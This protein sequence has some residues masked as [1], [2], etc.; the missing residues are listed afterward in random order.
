MTHKQW[1]QVTRIF[2]D[3]IEV[4][5]EKR[6][7]WLDD[8]C[9]DDNE[10]YK[11]VQSLLK[12]YTSPGLPDLSLKEVRQS[13]VSWMELQDKKG[14]QIGPYQ[15]QEM[16]G[17]GGM[18]VVYRAYDCRLDR[19]VAIK[20]PP[21]YWSLNEQTKKRFLNEARIAASLDHPNI[22]T[23]Y[24]ADELDDGT[25][26]MAMAF[27]Q[28]ETLQQRLEQGPLDLDDAVDLII[29]TASGLEAAHKK[30]LIHRDIKPANLILTQNGTLKVLDFGIA[31]A[32]DEGIT[33]S[34][35][36]PGTEAY[37]S[38]EQVHGGRVDKR[39]D[40]WSM[41]VIFYEMLTGELPRNEWVSVSSL[42][43]GVPARIDELLCQLL[44]PDPDNR[45]QSAGELVATLETMDGQFE[46]VDSIS[47]GKMKHLPKIGLFS[48][49]IL[50]L[51]LSVI[52]AYQV[53]NG[54]SLFS[55]ATGES[56]VSHTLAVLPFNNISGDPGDEYFSDGISEDLL[57]YLARNSGFSV[58]SRSTV[59]HY[60]DSGRA[61]PDIGRELGAT[62]IINGSVQRADNRVRINVQL[63]DAGS[64]HQ[65]WGDRYDREL[66]DIFEIQTDIVRSIA[67]RLEGHILSSSDITEPGILNAEAH[68][69]YLQGRFHWHR[70]S[71]DGLRK[72]AEF[73]EKAVEIEPEYSTAWEGLADAYAVLGFYDY[74][75][76]DQ[77]FPKARE[78]ARRALELK[79]NSASAWA[80]L[81]Y[82]ALYYDWNL[83]WGEAAFRRSINLDPRN[84]KAR[85]WYANMLTAAGRFDEAEREMLRAQE[86]DP[87]SLIANAA[88]GW[89]YYQA[90]KNEDAIRQLNFTLELNPDFELAY[91]WKGWTLEAMERYDE[92]LEMLE[93]A[94]SRST[95]SNIV[96]ASLARLHGLRGET[97]KAESLLRELEKSEMYIP[98]YEIGKAYLGL[99]RIEQAGLWLERAIDDRSH[100]MVFLKVDPQIS[101]YLDTN[102]IAD[103]AVRVRSESSRDE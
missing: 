52:S 39:T 47:R 55:W 5:G 31:M 93:E 38:P 28:G 25:L 33:F 85:Q 13:A 75:A 51:T 91:L 95:G 62:H 7:Q 61:I 82:V 1:L 78:A 71:E 68:D 43:P 102:P 76:P 42:H 45:M 63:I 88:L 40:L 50:L 59:M 80:N 2:A 26:F 98:A 16:I 81:G 86:L 32:A 73:F 87:L 96:V 79:P 30:G 20:F 67:E 6:D 56:V 37:M 72:A 29:Q 58:I 44:D 69:L 15:L 74:L 83:E 77:S 90:G 49:L 18:G 99:N 66:E 21:P 92:A 3:A 14:R 10:L 65:L 23:I 4:D 60:K 35:Q 64:G 70:R 36:Q 89:V 101:K 41:G 8:A 94:V 22:C 84:S 54:N 53:M 17:R 57:T 27:Y 46:A 103:L 19:D 97:D 34:E 11:E 100:S 9:G 12:A 24:E 48:G